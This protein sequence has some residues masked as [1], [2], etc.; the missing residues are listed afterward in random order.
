MKTDVK[1]RAMDSVNFY[2]RDAAINLIKEHGD[3]STVY[4][5]QANDLT[6]SITESDRRRVTLFRT[7]IQSSNDTVLT[8][9]GTDQYQGIL[10]VQKGQL[11][12]DF[13]GFG[14][15][16]PTYHYN[17]CSLNKF[18][19]ELHLKANTEYMFL[20]VGYHTSCITDY[21]VE[22]HPRV[23]EL[24]KAV[25]NRRNYCLYPHFILATMDM[26]FLAN[27]F[28]HTKSL[29]A[30]DQYLE[31][32]AMEL[33]LVAMLPLYANKTITTQSDQSVHR[34]VVYDFVNW[35]LESDGF[36]YPI[37][38][39]TASHRIPAY[40][41]LVEFQKLFRITTQDFLTTVRMKRAKEMAASGLYDV[42]AI[43]RHLGYSSKR[44]LREAF[45]KYWGVALR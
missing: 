30:E 26:L 17:V 19:C 4:T 40:R 33:L 1:T 15:E 18:V 42:A 25:T 39:F 32:K 38:Q 24:L 9:K 14:V 31:L 20:F 45:S 28:D 7:L 21:S 29:Y 5:A 41:F 23:G 8:I 3:Q 36:R 44:T 6:L 2:C 13:N 22:S 27:D 10:I 35:V 43:A 37:K 11:A 34:R 16:L 12:G